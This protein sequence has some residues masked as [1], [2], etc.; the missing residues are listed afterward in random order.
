MKQRALAAL[1]L[2]L[3]VASTIAGSIIDPIPPRPVEER[4]GYRVLEADFHAH[5]RFS[6]GFL[7][8]PDLVDQANRRGLDVLAVSEHN[9]IFPARIARWYSRLV[10]GPTIVLAEEV[11]TRDYH[12]LAI[13]IHDAVDASHGLASVIDE[14][15]AQGGVVAAAHPTLR[16][17]RALRPVI[18]RLDAMEVMHP[19][20]FQREGSTIGNASEMR[21]FYL[22]A[23]SH[24]HPVAPLG[25]SDYHA[26]SILGIVRTYVFVKGDTEAEIVDAIRARRTVTFDLDGRGF[27][28][29]ALVDA[30]V[31]NPIPPRATDYGY[32][33]AGTVDVVARV[34]GFVGVL[35]VL[36]FG[37]GLRKRRSGLQRREES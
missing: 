9:Q 11:T 30:L 2:L 5:T 37:L 36:A 33:G 34:A 16:Y 32:H 29:P 7:S 31:E 12:V 26:G 22:E 14:V 13:G 23:E 10:G 3:V 18:D 19:I 1:S 8:P 25:D 28:D 6:D 4:A 24:G 15:H 27:G 21:D 17:Q 35:G 20:A